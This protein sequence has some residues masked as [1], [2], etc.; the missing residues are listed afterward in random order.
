DLGLETFAKGTA[1][2]KQVRSITK[3]NFG[4]REWTRGVED[5]EGVFAELDVLYDYLRLSDEASSQKGL[6]KDATADLYRAVKANYSA[7]SVEEIK[8]LV[9]EDKWLATVEDAVRSE[10]ERITGQLAGRVQEL[11]ERY[12]EPLPDIED[13]VGMLARRV[14]KHLKTMGVL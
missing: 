12:A 11:E 6:L 4:T 14:D 8:T 1:R 5:P 7:L 2:Y 9:V 3:T 13:E 10:V